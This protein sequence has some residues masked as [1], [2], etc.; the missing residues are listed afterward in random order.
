MWWLAHGEHEVPASRGWLSAHEQEHL[1]SI[2]YTKRRDEYVTR[3]WTTKQAVAAVLGLQ[4]DDA[5]L[6]R[7]E[8]R[9]HESGAPFVHL[10][11]R[12]AQVE[13]SMSDRAGWAVCLAGAPGVATV[14]ALGIDLE[15]VEPR[16]DGFVEDYLTYCEGVFG[17]RIARYPHPSLYRWLNRFVFQSPE[18]LAIIEAAQ[19]P[20]PTY[21][22]MLTLVREDQGLPADTWVADGVRAA[23]S[24]VRRISIQKHGAMKVK[25][26]KVSVVWDWRKAHAFEAIASAGIDLAPD[27]E[28]FGRSFDGIDA[29]FT[30]PLR[31]HAPE[32]FER[33]L[34]WFP[35]AELD[36]VRQELAS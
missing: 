6:A 7:I 26:H 34:E 5:S 23:D 36:L 10:D 24:I 22:Q 16:T 1:A 28:W 14:G 25:H 21:E 15:I 11:G 12:D 20:E 18:R 2:R 17:C 13:V 8:V 19:F 35:L 9:H 29:R 4:G 33:I 3:R 32:D 27:Y 30:G 31:E